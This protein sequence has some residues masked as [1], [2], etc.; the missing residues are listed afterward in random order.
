V[1]H[2]GNPSI[3]INETKYKDESSDSDSE[4]SSNDDEDGMNLLPS[5]GKIQSAWNREMN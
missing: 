5:N 3:V 1:K 2:T 4:S